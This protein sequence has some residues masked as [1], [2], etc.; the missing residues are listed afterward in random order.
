MLPA[1]RADSTPA[2]VVVLLTAAVVTAAVTTL[3]RPT[4]R[5][6]GVGVCFLA[7]GVAVRLVSGDTDLAATWFL[8]ALGGIGLGAIVSAR[9]GA[10]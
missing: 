10:R 1:S 9:R 8:A 7:G 2:A 4:P 3:R 6:V 5:A